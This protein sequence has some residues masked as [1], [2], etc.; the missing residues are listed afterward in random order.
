MIYGKTA[1]ALATTAGFLTIGY[2]TLFALFGPWFRMAELAGG[3]PSETLL[4]KS[5]VIAFLFY[6]RAESGSK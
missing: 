4:L 6:S 1:F 5:N 2:W 3:Q